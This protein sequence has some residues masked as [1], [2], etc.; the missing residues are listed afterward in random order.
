M[1]EV[2]PQ[3][4]RDQRRLGAVLHA[5]LDTRNNRGFCDVIGRGAA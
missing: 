4:A 2:Q 1:L 3:R 5:Q